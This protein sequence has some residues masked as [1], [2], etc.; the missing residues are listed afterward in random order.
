MLH[1]ARGTHL[2]CINK[3]FHTG[4][5]HQVKITAIQWVTLLSPWHLI[6]LR[7]KE[8]ECEFTKLLQ[9]TVTSFVDIDKTLA[10]MAPPSKG[11]ATARIDPALL[12]AKLQKYFSGYVVSSMAQR[13]RKTVAMAAVP[14]LCVTA[15]NAHLESTKVSV[16]KYLGM[17][18]EVEGALVLDAEALVIVGD[19]KFAIQQF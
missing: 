17:K 11:S 3:I 14:K 15:A 6:V 10:P 1:T 4:M 5:T 18:K 16:A 19:S 13:R 12:Y 2:A 8:K 7:V 9:S